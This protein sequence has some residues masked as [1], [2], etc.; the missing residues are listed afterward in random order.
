MAPCGALLTGLLFTSPVKCPQMHLIRLAKCRLQSWKTS[1][2][3]PRCYKLC[4]LYCRAERGYS[5]PTKSSR[6]VLMS[7]RVHHAS[8]RQNVLTVMGLGLLE[9]ASNA[10]TKP[11]GTCDCFDR[12]NRQ[13]QQKQHLTLCNGHLRIARWW[14]LETSRPPWCGQ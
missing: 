12:Y 11:V 9:L 6:V 7:P 3:H 10:S 13:R 1:S 14:K 5:K 2:Q 4:R 8:R